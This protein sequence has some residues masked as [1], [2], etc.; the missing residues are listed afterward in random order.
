MGHTIYYRISIDGWE[1]FRDFLEKVCEGLGFRVVGGEDSVIILPE[2]RG[3]EPLEIKKN[4]EGFVKTNLVE[5][6]HSIY[7]LL[8]HSV[9]SF[10]SVELWE[11]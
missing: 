3:V 1:E 7:L 9:S 6:C 11:D 2:C 10:G 5:P 4:G 8:L